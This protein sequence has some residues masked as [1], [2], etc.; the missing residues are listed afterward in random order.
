MIV[1][2]RILL[3][4]DLDLLVHAMLIFEY[5]SSEKDRVLHKLCTLVSMAWGFLTEAI[6]LSYCECDYIA[7]FSKSSSG[8]TKTSTGI[9]HYGIFK[10]KANHI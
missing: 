4:Q 1:P 2:G 6:F 10:W 8:K 7:H 3:E 5:W 9:T